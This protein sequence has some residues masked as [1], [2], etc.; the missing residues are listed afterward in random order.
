MWLIAISLLHTVFPKD[1]FT[2][3]VSM[4]QHCTQRTTTTT[5][6]S[7]TSLSV[8]ASS[9]VHRMP[10]D[11]SVYRLCNKLLFH[12]ALHNA[13]E[14]L[15]YNFARFEEL[16]DYFHIHLPCRKRT[17]RDKENHAIQRSLEFYFEGQRYDA[18]GNAN[19]VIFADT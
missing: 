11:D 4:C 14:Y 10:W 12:T 7:A 9:P 17:L 3:N 6:V 8:T 2:T 13:A 15:T 1:L 18:V 19:E 16:H 5:S